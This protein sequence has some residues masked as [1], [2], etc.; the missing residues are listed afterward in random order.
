MTSGVIRAR[1]R[2]RF[3]WRMISW[4]AANEMRWVKPSIAT[5]SPSRTTSRT[6]SAIDATFEAVTD[7]RRCGRERDARLQ[8]RRRGGPAG[9]NRRANGRSDPLG[10]GLRNVP[11]PVGDD[12]PGE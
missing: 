2:L 6:A 3:R 7:A 1:V 4:P 5:V 8:Y 10:F 9:P 11:V 12:A